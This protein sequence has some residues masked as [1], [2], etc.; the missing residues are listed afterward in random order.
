[1]ILSIHFS[2]CIVIL[3]GVNLLLINNIKQIPHFMSSYIMTGLPI[4]Q[5]TAYFKFLL[6]LGLHIWLSSIYFS[7]CAKFLGGGGGNL[8]LINNIML[9]HSPP[10]ALYVQFFFFFNG[11]INNFHFCSSVICVFFFFFAKSMWNPNTQ[12]P[13]IFKVLTYDRLWCV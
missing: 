3:G 12:L 11:A 2:N 7:S 1:M 8:L 5:L 4:S 6:L 13:Y 9:P 10:P